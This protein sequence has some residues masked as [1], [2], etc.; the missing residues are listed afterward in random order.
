[1]DNSS[2]GA[3][4]AAEMSDGALEEYFME[5]ETKSYFTNYSM[6][7]SVLPRSEALVDLDDQFEKVNVIDY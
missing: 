7:S 1:M 3:S 6:S 2:D 5:E 4:D